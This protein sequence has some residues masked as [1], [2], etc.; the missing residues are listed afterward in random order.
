[1]NIE[2]FAKKPELIKIEITD[3]TIVEGYGQPVV[4]WIYDSV[5][6]AT[7]FD[8]FKSQ[9]DNDGE[10][11]NELVRKLIRNQQGETCIEEG[12]VLPV[13]LAIASLTAINEHLG[14]SRTKLS[15]PT[16]GNQPD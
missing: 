2:Q 11:L 7:Y 5:D 6:I 10:K 3:T 15:T 12:H 1:M 9:A 13:D 14:K 16:T 4:F 8:F